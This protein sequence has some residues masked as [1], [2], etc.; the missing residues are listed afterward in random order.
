MSDVAAEAAAAVAATTVAATD[1][2]HSTAAVTTG[3]ANRYPATRDG[4]HR[5]EN[6]VRTAIPTGSA[7]ITDRHEP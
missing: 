3:T 6:V 1:S 4:D 7:I 2:A 5:S